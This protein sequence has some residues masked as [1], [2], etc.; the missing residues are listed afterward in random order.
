ME[1][2]EVVGLE[3]GK[4]LCSVQVKGGYCEF[5]PLQEGEERL[6]HVPVE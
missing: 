5:Q 4:S 6:K 2:V 1:L 3:W